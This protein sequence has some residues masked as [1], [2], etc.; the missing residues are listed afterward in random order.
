MSARPQKP[1]K[2]TNERWGVYSFRIEELQGGVKAK[3][4]VVAPEFTEAVHQVRYLLADRLNLP[5]KG[6]EK[7]FT[8]KG[9]AEVVTLGYHSEG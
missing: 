4:V 7:Y 9:S 2:A 6:I 5:V 8:F 3:I 1:F